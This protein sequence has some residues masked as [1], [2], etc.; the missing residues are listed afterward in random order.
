VPRPLSLPSLI[1]KVRSG[2]V[3]IDVSACDG[4]DE[5]TGF[6]LDRRHIVTVE[7]VI[8]GATSIR[9]VRDGAGLAT[10]TVVGTDPARD[11]ALLATSRPIAGYHFMISS[12]IPALGDEVAT[13][14][15]PLNLPLSLTRGVVSGSDRTIPIGG[16]QRRNL[17]QTD[18]SINPG[19]SGG[20][21]ISTKTGKVVGLIDL[22]TDQANG[23]AFAVSG[24]VAAPLLQAWTAARQ[25]VAATTCQPPAPPPVAPPAPPPAPSP[26]SPPGPSGRLYAITQDVTMYDA[27]T[28]AGTVVGAIPAGTMVGVQCK[29]VGQTVNGTWGQDRYWDQITYGGTTGFVTDEWVDTKQDEH[30]P[31]KVP[32][33]YHGGEASGAGGGSGS[34]GSS[35]GRDYSLQTIT[36][37]GAVVVLDDGSIWSIDVGDQGTTS[38]WTDGDS[39]T[40]ASGGNSLVDTNSGDVVTATR[41]GS[42]TDSNAYANTGDHTLQATGDDGSIVTLDDGSIWEVPNTGD[43]STV[44]GWTD[45]DSI[46]VSE[47]PNGTGYIITDTD[48]QSSVTAS[49]IGSE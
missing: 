7:H 21:L 9:L 17:I 8:H 26:V 11:L 47:D 1:A 49:Y 43:Q 34:G 6:L 32:P 23:L 39:I 30:D 20:P 48:D 15:F 37:D 44:S 27:P 12:R 19:N 3:K 18:A 38:S 14:G 33:C 35:A 46:T 5:G 4:G 28:D 10:A 2:V 29:A 22:E 31:S 13:L 25:P 36:D 41:V 40:V 16:L 24:Q 45:G 42:D